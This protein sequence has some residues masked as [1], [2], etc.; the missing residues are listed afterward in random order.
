MKKIAKMT[1]LGL[2]TIIVVFISLYSPSVYFR[3]RDAKLSEREYVYSEYSGSISPEAD[4]IYM[5]KAIQKLYGMNSS[6]MFVEQIPVNSES[7][8]LT[9][10]HDAKIVNDNWQE[11]YLYRLLIEEESEK[12]LLLRAYSSEKIIVDETSVLENYIKYL[13]LDVLDD[14]EA[15]ELG[16]SS[17]KAC[18]QIVYLYSEEIELLAVAPIGYFNYERL[19]ELMEGQMLQQ[20]NEQATMKDKVK[21]PMTDN[22]NETTIEF[23]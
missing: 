6:L 12:V 3:L 19:F 2:A 22:T 8:F 10:L 15:D 17:Q 9:S 20:T 16:L 4:E 13:G 5:V 1:A 7:D 18:L 11:V 14:W 21:I 23:K